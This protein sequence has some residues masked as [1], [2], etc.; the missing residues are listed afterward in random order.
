[1]RIVVLGIVGRSPVAGVAW[2]ALHYLEGLRRLGHDVHYVE[3][4]GDW[5]YDAEQDTVT[6]DV[7]YTLAYLGRL[8]AWCGLPG[9]WAYRAAAQGGRSFGLSD[10]ELARLI[11]ETDVLVNV[12]GSTILGDE[13]LAV[14]VRIY[15]ET[16][17]VLA[18]IEIAKGEAATI[19]L[20]GAHTHHFTFGEN[21]GSGDC[22]IPVGR[23]SY[24]PTRQPVVLDWW[25]TEA[26]PAPGAPF[27]T[28][29]T[30]A[31][32]G[33]DIEWEGQTYTWSKHGEFLKVLDLPR[34]TTERLELALASRDPG[35][36]GLL[37]ANGWSVRDALALSQDIH[38]YREYVR[39]SRGEFTVAKPQ[40]TLSR[41][42][43]FSDRSACYLAAG[44]PVVTQET[45]F[46]KFLPTGRGLFAFTTGDDIVAALD[47]IAADYDA[48]A[49]AARDIAAEYFAAEKVLAHLLSTAGLE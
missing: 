20:Y 49:A 25:A 39:A 8:M 33:K 23:F 41:S 6:D 16:D 5:P 43:W 19:A 4:T 26:T 47:A 24:H 21:L 31:Q 13:Y 37:R 38:P 14:P 35:V 9:R 32:A 17:P 18:Q 12:T 10:D 1:V 42:G 40:Y 27:T 7:R 44:R 22:P 36:I 2:Q 45:G 30:W 28:V 11:A 48:Q 34:R 15:L 29:A 3:D 46:S